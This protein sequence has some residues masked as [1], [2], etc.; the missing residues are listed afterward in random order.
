MARYI[1]HFESAIDGTRFPAD[2][3]QTWHEGRPLWSR[4]DLDAIRRA[5]SPKQIASR[6]ATMW[7]YR[8]LLP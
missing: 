3:L 2:R 7:R 8:E 6:P 4:Y 1:K 5:V